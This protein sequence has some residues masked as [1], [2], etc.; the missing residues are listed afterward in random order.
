[1]LCNSRVEAWILGSLTRRH[2]GG[3]T[4]GNK[5]PQDFELKRKASQRTSEVCRY[6]HSTWAALWLVKSEE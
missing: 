4:K 6:V 1:M 5:I 2:L 3:Y